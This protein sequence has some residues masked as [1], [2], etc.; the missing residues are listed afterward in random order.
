LA[1]PW[2]RAEFKQGADD[3]AERAR[4]PERAYASTRIRPL[5]LASARQAV[6]ENRTPLTRIYSSKGR[7]KTAP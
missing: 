7:N 2:P 5:R 4:K 1:Q 6:C 3:L